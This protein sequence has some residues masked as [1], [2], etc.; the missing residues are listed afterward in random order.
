V[1]RGSMMF[2]IFLLFFGPSQ[3]FWTAS[4]VQLMG[5]GRAEV[6]LWWQHASKAMR[7]SRCWQ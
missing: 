4:E 7:D 3:T 2:V 5:R 6:R 1:R